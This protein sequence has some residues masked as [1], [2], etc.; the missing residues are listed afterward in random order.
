MRKCSKCKEIKTEEHFRS[1]SF[2]YCRVCSSAYDKARYRANLDAQRER[3]RSYYMRTRV[4]TGRRTV[5]DRFEEWYE[6]VTE[7]GC[8]IWLGVLTEQGY[9]KA[10]LKGKQI[11]AHRLSWM[12]YRGSIPDGMF[13]CHKCDNPLCVNP[14]HLFLGAQA[15]NSNDKVAKGRQ[16]RKLSPAVVDAIRKSEGSHVEIAAKFGVS[17][18]HVGN[19]KA[20]VKPLFYSHNPRRAA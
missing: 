6:P 9:G 5:L 12:K 16:W 11:G 18:S 7:T 10:R 20:G 1:S 19:I 17:S 4:L 3:G 2:A 13:I 14:D 15:D 8:W